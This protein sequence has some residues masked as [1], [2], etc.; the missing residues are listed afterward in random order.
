MTGVLTLCALAGVLVYVLV[1]QPSSVP[2]EQTVV[3]PEVHIERYTNEDESLGLNLV[4]ATSG[5]CINPIAIGEL[6]NTKNDKCVDIAGSNGIGNVGSWACDG[7]SDQ[8]IMWCADGSLRNSA[9]NY[10]F[11]KSG[12]NLQSSYC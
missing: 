4:E 8:K 12:G 9:I 1:T 2:G 7:Y 10:C 5:E 6:R 11:T 3:A